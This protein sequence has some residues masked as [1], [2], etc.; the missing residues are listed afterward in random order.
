MVSG[1]LCVAHGKMQST[2]LCDGASP[3]ATSLDLALYY[4]AMT[5]HFVAQGEENGRPRS[6]RRDEWN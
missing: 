2:S 6:R 1:D 5:N 4:V 3:I